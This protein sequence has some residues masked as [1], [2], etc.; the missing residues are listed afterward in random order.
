M[1]HADIGVRSGAGSG[2]E[3]RPSLV[4]Q[5]VC[6]SAIVVAVIVAVFVPVLIWAAAI[7]LTG[8]R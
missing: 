4:V 2:R 5:K 1:G 8:S 3:Q 6:L 7:F